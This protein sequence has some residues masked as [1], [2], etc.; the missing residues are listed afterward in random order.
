M[1]TL[2]KLWL[3]T[4][5]GTLFIFG[6]MGAFASISAFKIFDIFDPIADALGDFQVTDIV[7]SQLREDPIADE[8]IVLVNIGTETRG[9]IGVMVDKINQY[10]PAVIGMDTFFDVPKDTLE[11]MI[12]E[13]AL[14]SVENLVMVTQM[15]IYDEDNVIDSLRVSIPAFTRNAEYAHAN[16][17]AEAEDQDDLKFCRQF[18]PRRYDDQG[19]AQVAL[20]IKLASY[21]DSARAQKF[22][23]RDNDIELINFKGN[24]I[25]FGATKYGTKYYALDV[26]DVFQDNFTPEIIEGKI[27]IFCFLGDYIGDR[28]STEDKYITPLNAKYAGRTLPDMYGGVIHANIISMV[29]SDDPVNV[30]G[31]A[32]QI[33]SAILLCVFNVFLF[34][35]IYKR[36]PKWYDGSTKVFQL[37]ELMVLYFVMLQV[38]D[39][40]NYYV[41]LTFGLIAVALSG[42][43]LEVYYGVIKNTFTKEGRRS[44]FKADR[45]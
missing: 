12:L 25:D 18:W 40:Y 38:F 21:L 34:S 2:K 8:R 10:N 9:S 27:V 20:G 7:F 15:L 35:I 37:L 44:L 30:M 23:D 33:A 22:L 11:D 28:T 1:R 3:D 41:D 39:S 45:I 31:Q 42:D 13:G 6:I 17:D 19:N 26:L 43:A 24:V 29:L 36:I 14:A 5:L 32:G 16:L 4:I